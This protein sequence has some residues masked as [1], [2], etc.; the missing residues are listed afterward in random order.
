M[1]AG[2]PPPYA[3][4]GTD[5][6]ITQSA[7]NIR[8]ESLS[9]DN[10]QGSNRLLHSYLFWARWHHSYF[11][12]T[13][14][15]TTHNICMDSVLAYVDTH[16]LHRRRNNINRTCRVIFDQRRRYGSS[17][18]YKNDLFIYR[19][20]PC[21]HQMPGGEVTTPEGQGRPKV[22]PPPMYWPKWLLYG[23]TSCCLIYLI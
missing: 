16:Q 15:P 5:G 4:S 21:M 10:G 9:T 14:S 8:V 17:I 19:H 13:N 6:F 11:E 1:T 22:P 23:G 3:T 20:N 12:I 2:Q 18:I 7:G